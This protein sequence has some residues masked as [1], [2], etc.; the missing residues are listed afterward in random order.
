MLRTVGDQPTLWESIL[1]PA[2]LRIPEE[3]ERVDRFLDDARFFEPYP[4]F[5]VSGWDDR[6][7]RSRRICG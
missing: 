4:A 3:L 5:S 2:A 6:R 7:C 1:P